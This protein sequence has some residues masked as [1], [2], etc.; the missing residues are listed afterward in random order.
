[1]EVASWKNPTEI[2]NRKKW[3]SSEILIRLRRRQP[4]HDRVKV[5]A[6]T[7]R[8]YAT[9]P[10]QTD[11][12]TPETHKS[13][14]TIERCGETITQEKKRSPP[15]PA[16]PSSSVSFC[17]RRSMHSDDLRSFL[18]FL[19]LFHDRPMLAFLTAW[20]QRN[21][22]S[23][24]AQPRIPHLGQLARC[25]ARISWPVGRKMSECFLPKTALV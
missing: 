1:M 17:E 23:F 12:V 7:R 6:L 13:T 2:R 20:V 15:P 18:F 8:C 11:H 22:A 10:K 19:E 21:R 9:N 25:R 14:T 3:G 5:Y 16:P 4:P 24:E